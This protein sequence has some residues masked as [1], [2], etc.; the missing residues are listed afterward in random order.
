MAAAVHGDSSD[1]RVPSI[2]DRQRPGGCGVS[3]PGVLAL[4][5]RDLRPEPLVLASQIR[6]R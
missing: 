6:R 2:S 3:L 4:E 5:V 1:G